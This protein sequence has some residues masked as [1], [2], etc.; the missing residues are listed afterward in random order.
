MYDHFIEALNNGL[1]EIGAKRRGEGG[2]HKASN[3][4]TSASDV[5]PPPPDKA[6]EKILKEQQAAAD[7]AEQSIKNPAQNDQH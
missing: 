4:G 1:G 6:A 7:K 5:P 2:V 3:A